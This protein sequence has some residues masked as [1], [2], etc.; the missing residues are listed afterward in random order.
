MNFQLF[1]P[2][3]YKLPG[4]TIKYPLL[5]ICDEKCNESKKYLPKI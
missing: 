2:H 4:I 3:K 5:C 1:G